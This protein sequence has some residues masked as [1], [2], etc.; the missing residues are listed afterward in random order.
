MDHG[1]IGLKM[2]QNDFN[3][4]KNEYKQ[5]QLE[6][7]IAKTFYNNIPY[8]KFA[9]KTVIFSFLVIFILLTSYIYQ[10]S[11]IVDFLAYLGVAIFIGFFL[12]SLTFIETSNFIINKTQFDTSYLDK[13]KNKIEQN[14]KSKYDNS[15]ITS[16]IT[17]FLNELHENKE[18]PSCKA[19]VQLC[20][21]YKTRFETSQYFFNKM[22]K[23]IRKIAQNNQIQEYIKEYNQ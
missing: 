2:E 16:A 12:F 22:Q 18:L 15:I 13:V 6:Y 5:K 9:Q 7:E 23:N 4:V 11:N 21:N 8:L 20:E 14:L 3:K 1:K 19:I 17:E 10:N